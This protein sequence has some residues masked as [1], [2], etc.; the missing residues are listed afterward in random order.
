MQRAFVAV[1]LLGLIAGVIPA[2]LG[3]TGSA[4]AQDTK[5]EDKPEEKKPSVFSPR[6]V[7]Q[8]YLRLQREIQECFSKKEYAAAEEKCKAQIAMVPQDPQAHYNLACA[9]ARLGKANE[10]LKS[11]DTAIEAGFTD[12][13]HIR[14]DDDLESL[15]EKPAFAA[16]VEKAGKFVARPIPAQLAPPAGVEPTPIEKGEGIVGEKNSA[17]DAGYGVFR[18]YFKFPEPPLDKPIADGLGEAGDLLRAWAK[19]GTAAGNQGDLYDNHDGDHSNMNYDSFPQL[20]R[21]EFSEEAKTRRVHYGMQT[22]LF[23]NG[24]TLGN[25]STALTNGP[26][27]RSQAR[28]ALTNP[29]HVQI[30]VAQYYGN[31]LFMYPEHRDHDPGRN[32]KNDGFG[33][34]FF[35]NTPYILTS[36][37]S[38]GSDIVHLNAVAAVLAA[39]RP[40]V[41]KKLRENGALMPA[42]QMVYRSS[43]KKVEKPADYH[44]GKAHPTVFEGADIDMARLVKKAHDLTADKLPPVIQLRAIEEDRPILGRDYFDA[45]ERER[46][47]DTPAAIARVCKST[48]Y[49]RRMVVSAETSRDLNGKPLKFHWAVLRGDPAKIKVSPRGDAGATAEI[50][51]AYQERRPI[52]EGSAMESNRVDIGVFA[53]NGDVESSPGFVSF[54]FLDD[55]KRVYGEKDRIESVD[56]TGG[57]DGRNY[58]DPLIN[59]PK[60]WRDDYH[61]DP[62]GKLTGWTRTRGDKKEEFTPEGK[63]IVKLGGEGAMQE[64]KD[65]RYSA[66]GGMNAVPELVQ[67]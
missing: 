42:V 55:E 56:Y 5:P 4:S 54:Y 11:L 40:E 15:R 58:V 53:T 34:T 62:A 20:T 27:W 48:Q 59:L 16:A 6:A 22:L 39:F 10:A 47:L 66:K 57:K 8:N 19:E 67:E 38:S 51:V 32:G 28:M 35:C 2:P 7:G 17:F 24:V 36:Q 30:L 1:M 52:T 49:R 50:E 23:Y 13:A 45:A 43:S 65:V 41:K 12:P 29:R 21:I 33:D 14:H 18:V 9:L 31:H 44:T 37:G 60:N 46:L 25:S 26:M 64:T 3:A 61:Y 63:L